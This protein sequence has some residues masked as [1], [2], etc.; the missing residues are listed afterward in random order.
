MEN[1]NFYLEYLNDIKSIAKKN[2]GSKEFRDISSAWME[3]STRY[4]YSYLFTFMG[5]PI[6]Q[7][8]QDMVILQELIWNVKPD[9]IV[10]TGIAHGGSLVLSASCLAL[11]DVCE[12]KEGKPITPR[13]VVGIDIDIRKHNKEAIESHPLSHWIHTIQGSSIDSEVFSEIQNIAKNYQKVLVILDSD[14]TFEHVFAELQLY[15]KLVSLGSYCIVFD[16]AIEN[17]PKDLYP[18]RSWGPGNN[19]MKAVS[20]FIEEN[21]DFEVDRQIDDRLMI[22]VAPFGY[23]KKIK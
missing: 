8:P 18:N 17:L 5:R 21:S 1:E 23:L 4:K 19:P 14:H 10:E 3:I 2:G 20:K 13:K 6:I 15:S 7:L 22:S 12:T 11:L 9:L 16:T